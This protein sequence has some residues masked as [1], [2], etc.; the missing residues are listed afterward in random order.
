[1]VKPLTQDDQT[2]LRNQQ[3]IKSIVLRRI[4]ILTI[5]MVGII[6]VV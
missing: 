5:I 3:E 1:M 6:I 4:I 2:K